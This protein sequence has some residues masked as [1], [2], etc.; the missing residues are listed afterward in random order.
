N[1]ALTAGL[2]GGFA[3]SIKYTAFIGMLS[4]FLALSVVFHKE[5]ITRKKAGEWFLL[6]APMALLL[7]PW[8]LKNY[9]F[10]GNFVY[11]YL[12]SLFGG[13]VFPPEN[14]KALLGDHE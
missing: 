11:P 10:T 8:L 6:L 4:G 14:M 9:E 13:R 2:L 3:L 5:L 12:S 1:W 7:A